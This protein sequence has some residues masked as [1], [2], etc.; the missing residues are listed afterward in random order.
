MEK[1]LLGCVLQGSSMTEHMALHVV[2]PKDGAVQNACKY[3]TRNQNSETLL[4]GHVSWLGF[5]LSFDPPRIKKK[6]LFLGSYFPLGGC[7]YY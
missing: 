6:L 7:F 1:R 3:S 5:G 2:N 4:Y